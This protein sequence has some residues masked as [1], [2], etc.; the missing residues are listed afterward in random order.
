QDEQQLAVE[1]RIMRSEIDRAASILASMLTPVDASPSMEVVDLNKLASTVHV[2][3]AGA[4]SQP[5]HGVQLQLAPRPALVRGNAGML[6]QVLINLVK[7]AMEALAGE[8]CVTLST[9]T[10]IWQ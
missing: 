6:K 5:A 4:H 10:N 9:Q 7:N 1:L 2:V 3:F 8:G